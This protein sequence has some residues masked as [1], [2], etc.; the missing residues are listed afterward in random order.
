[1]V[2]ATPSV[3]AILASDATPGQVLT[4]EFITTIRQRSPAPGPAPFPGPGRGPAPDTL[5]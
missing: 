1:M 4:D 5:A 3:A 2:S